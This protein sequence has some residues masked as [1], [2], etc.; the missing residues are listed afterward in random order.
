MLKTEIDVVPS[1]ASDEWF[2]WFEKHCAFHNFKVIGKAAI[3]D[4]RF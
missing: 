2:G 1:A 4:N 3:A